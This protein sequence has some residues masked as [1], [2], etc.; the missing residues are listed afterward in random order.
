M[1]TKE[2][3]PM[4]ETLI[5]EVMQTPQESEQERLE[6]SA[7]VSELRKY[8]MDAHVLRVAHT[9]ELLAKA[10]GLN[11]KIQDV[12]FHASQLYD[13][14]KTNISDEILLKSD[15][16]TSDEFE[17]IKKHAQA[18]YDILKYSQNAYLK[19]AAVV[20]YSHHEKFDGSGYPMGLAGEAIPALG[21]IVALID[22]FEALT[23]ER[24]Y[25][26]A[27]SIEE[28]CLVLMSQKGKHFDPNLVDIFMQNLE[29]IKSI[30]A[31]FTD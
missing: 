4:L 2:K 31:R 3:T 5:E 26:E 28:A 9:A 20:A 12:A 19:A 30:Q 1:N 16:L 22:V 21:R 25:K 11:E 10:A 24:P 23:Y 17:T 8:K 14:G 15:K 6:V 29:E 13:I 7:K 18:G 27:W